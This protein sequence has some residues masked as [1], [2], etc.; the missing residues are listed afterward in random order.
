MTDLAGQT[1]LTDAKTQAVMA[2]LET[3]RPGSARFVGGCVRNALMGLE[4]D[5]IDIATQLQPDAVIAALEAASIRAIPTGIEHGTIT[6]V[7]EGRP[8]E[9]TTLRRDVETDGRR[10][11]VAFTE[12]WA[13]DAGRRDFRLNAL[14]AEPDGTL[15]DPTGGG[16]EDAGHG[17]VIFIG[18]ADTRLKE[19]YL[20]ILRFFRFNAWYG[21]G[22]DEAGLAA[23]A[24]QKEGL[25]QIASERIWKELHKLLA[26]P[27]PTEAVAAMKESG[28]LDILL[29][30]A[31][32]LEGLHDLRVSETLARV[33]PDPML[34]LMGLIHRSANSI[35]AVSKRLRLSNAES[36][37]LT[38]WAAD[39]LPDVTALNGR[40][41]RQALYW[42]GRQAVV[43]RALTSGRDVRDLVH[44]VLAWKRPEFPIGGDDALAAGLKGPEIGKA[45]RALEEWWMAEDFQPDRDTLLA[46]L[47]KIS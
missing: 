35:M 32:T 23:C 21:A 30:E 38:M 44:A 22:I 36:N 17:R 41:L 46:R 1:W 31:E 29:P 42:H 43:D 14:Y 40:E 20:R 8:F 37:R 15:H 6:A 16:I 33:K 5:D 26:A 10:A 28:V 47:G 4:V 7:C 19:D 9:I 12:D 24:R 18:D 34:R 27:D 3:A 25:K 39:N 45:L 2:A 13:E 11:V